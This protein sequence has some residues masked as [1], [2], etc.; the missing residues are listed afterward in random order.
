MVENIGPAVPNLTVLCS[1]PEITGI[2]RHG[3]IRQV[4]V[5]AFS[6]LKN[7]K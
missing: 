1:K 5:E 3:I 4:V 6:L 2:I 7:S